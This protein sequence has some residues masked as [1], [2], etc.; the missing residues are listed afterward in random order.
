MPSLIPYAELF[1]ARQTAAQWRQ[2]VVQA[3]SSIESGAL[4]VTLEFA[5][6]RVSGLC[7]SGVRRGLGAW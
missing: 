4:F 2:A 5:L 1:A 3:L 7:D 6:D